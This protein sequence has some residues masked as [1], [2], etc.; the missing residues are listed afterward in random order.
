MAKKFITTLEF[1]LRPF[2]LSSAL[3]LLA[4]PA[5]AKP[6]S[7]C[8]QLADKAQCEA[9]QVANVNLCQ[10]IDMSASYTANGPRKSYCRMSGKSITKEQ[11][12][13]LQA[14]R[15]ASTQN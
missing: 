8:N 9:L 14:A 13:A 10:W 15:T 4:V 12:E 1:G 5:V 6:K 11:W 3:I 2:V 7:Q